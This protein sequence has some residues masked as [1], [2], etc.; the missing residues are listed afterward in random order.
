MALRPGR[1][2][3]VRPSP[4][5]RAVRSLGDV[6]GGRPRILIVGGGQVG[7][8]A[9]L[10]LSRRLRGIRADVVLVNPESFMVYQSFL[11]EAASGS[12]EPRHVVVPLRPVLKRVRL[13]TGEV[14]ALD[15]ERRTARVMPIAGSPFDI[16]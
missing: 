8:F 5:A 1:Q 4:E 15:H 6:A 2:A 14:T 13:I 12:I 11:P 3:P 7:L 16:P 10:G 9:A